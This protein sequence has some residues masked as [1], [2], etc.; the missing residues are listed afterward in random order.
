VPCVD[1]RRMQ[2]TAQYAA[3]NAGHAAGHATSVLLYF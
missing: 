3:A 1:R 2:G